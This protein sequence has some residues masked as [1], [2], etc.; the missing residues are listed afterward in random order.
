MVQPS[1][2]TAVTSS[3]DRSASSSRPTLHPTVAR[4]V[5]WRLGQVHRAGPERIQ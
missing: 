4:R 1:A 5:R 3:S 2:K